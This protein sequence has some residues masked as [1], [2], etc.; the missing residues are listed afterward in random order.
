[1]NPKEFCK[2]KANDP[3]INIF[4]KPTSDSEAWNIV[5]DHILGPNW[6]VVDPLG[7]TQI[8]TEA[9][10]DILWKVPSYAYW[11]LP[12]YKRNWIRIKVLWRRHII[13]DWYA[14]PSDYYEEKKD[15]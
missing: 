2:M 13:G 15:H 7:R 6:Y 5:M 8:N 11:K 4:P 14:H 12:W 3:E 10:A 1:M 9:L